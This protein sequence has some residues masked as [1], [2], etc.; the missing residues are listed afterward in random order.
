MSCPET[1][2]A[3]FE[4]CCL[5]LNAYLSVLKTTDKVYNYI[6]AK[7]TISILLIIISFYS[8]GFPVIDKFGNG[9]ATSI[10]SIDITAESFMKGNGLFKTLK[11]Y[12]NKLGAFQGGTRGGVSIDA[13]DI[14]SKVLDVAIQPGKVTTAQWEQLNNALKYAKDNNVQLNFK[15]VK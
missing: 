10:K 2:N 5:R 11:G 7:Q 8:Y 12:V 13:D 4:V 9:V 15:F 3:L 6:T 14:T 1:R